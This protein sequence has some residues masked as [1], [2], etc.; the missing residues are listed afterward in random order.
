VRIK[1]DGIQKAGEPRKI[2]N[3]EGKIRL[4][5]RVEFLIKEA[6]EFLKTQ[7]DLYDDADRKVVEETFGGIIENLREAEKSLLS[8]SP[9]TE[10]INRVEKIITESYN[11]IIIYDL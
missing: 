9:D 11:D 4:R 5:V 8:A 1:V 7:T 10:T 3:K 2:L 6:E